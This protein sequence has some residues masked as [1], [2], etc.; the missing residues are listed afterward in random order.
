MKLTVKKKIVAVFFGLLGCG[1]L[2]AQAQVKKEILIKGKV[3]VLNPEVFKK[4]NMVWLYK[5][6]GKGKR[7]VDSVAVNADGS[8]SLRVLKPT[9][10]ALYQLDILKWQTASFWSDEDV[11]ISARGYDTARVK[12][13]NSG[14]IAVESKSHATQLI[15]SVVYN[16]Y[17]AEKEMNLLTEES[18]AAFNHKAKDSTWLYYLRSKGLIKSKNENEALRLKQM[19]KSNE[20]NPALVYLV[21]MLPTEKDNTFFETTLNKLIVRYPQMEEAK[22]LKKEYLD[23]KAIRNSLKTGSEIPTIVYNNPDGKPVDVK[24]FKGKY[25][26]IDFWASWC[27]PCRKAIPEIKTLYSQYKEKGFDVL[28]VSI[29]TDNAAWRKAM[30]EE[31]MPWTQVLSPDKNKTL[32]DFMIMGVPTLFLVDKEGKIVEKYTGFSAKLKTQ[33][34]DIFKDKI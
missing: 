9:T 33:L 18:Y 2:T 5:G 30:S 17:L 15:N 14:Y 26:L 7:I 28:S 23:K 34:E 27:G 20:D 11:Y 12:T 24:S 21:A 1:I 22:Q 6:I 25:V 29:D 13:K 32:A 4:Y 31:D 8:F 3:A 10:P 16:Q 19:I